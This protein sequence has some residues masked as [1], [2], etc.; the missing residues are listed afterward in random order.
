[1]LKLITPQQEDLMWVK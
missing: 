1:M